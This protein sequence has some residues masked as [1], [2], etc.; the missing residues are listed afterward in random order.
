MGSDLLE[1]KRFLF[2]IKFFQKY[3][4][5]YVI[6]KTQEMKDLIRS[7][8][9]VVIPNGVNL[10]IFKPIEKKY[11]QNEL[12]WE[13]NKIHILFAANPK[14]SV[15]NYRLFQESLCMLNDKLPRINV[16][17]LHQIPSDKVPIHM[18]AADVVCLSSIREGS[19][20]VVKEAMA[21]NRPIV[22]TDVGDVKWILGDTAGCYLSITQKSSE[23]AQALKKA[24]MFSKKKGSTKGRDRIIGLGLD[25]EKTA[26]KLLSIYH[27]LLN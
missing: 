14:R 17:F 8:N 12:N 6:V 18:N 13:S 7:K 22:T 25:S 11:C 27:K 3:F 26:D 23:Y 5:N 20:N 24:I 1:D 19:P 21:C 15:K 2:L 9:T 10:S 16:H 4:W